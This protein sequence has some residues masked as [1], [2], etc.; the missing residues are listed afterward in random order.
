MD[1]DELIEYYES[2]C[3]MPCSFRGSGCPCTDTADALRKLQAE[4]QRLRWLVLGED[5]DE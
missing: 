3:D 1:T 4:N 2:G 5:D